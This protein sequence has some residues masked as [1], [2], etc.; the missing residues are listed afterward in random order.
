M[1]FWETAGKLAKGAAN[2]LDEKAHEL[3]A[4]KMRLESKS[5]EDLKRLIKSDGFFG[6]ASNTEKSMAMKILRERGDV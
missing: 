4:T 2:A 3:Q 6:S 5:N 1:G